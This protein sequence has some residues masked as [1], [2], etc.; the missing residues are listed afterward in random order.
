MIQQETA[1][2]TSFVQKSPRQDVFA[3]NMEN[4]KDL[5][6]RG[7]FQSVVDAINNMDPKHL[8]QTSL[9]R[10]NLLKASAFFEMQRME[11]ANAVLREIG[12]SLALEPNS[13]ELG[14]C[15]AR[16]KY[17]GSDLEGADEIWQELLVT[18]SSSSIRV[19]S[20]IGIANVHYSRQEWDK[21][22]AL[23]P[24]LDVDE[25]DLSKDEELSIR[26]LKANYL[27][28]SE[29]SLGEATELFTE[30]IAD[31]TSI[32]WNY[33]VL[34][35]I[36]GLA[37][38]SQKK[39]NLTSLKVYVTTLKSM[40]KHSDNRLLMSLIRNRFSEQNISLPIEV[41]VDYELKRVKI[42]EKWFDFHKTPMLFHFF[43]TLFGTNTFINKEAIAKSLWPHEIYKPRTHDPRI[44]N[45][46]K[47]VREI[48]DSY[49]SQPLVILSGRFGYKLAAR[50][51]K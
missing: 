34:R 50:Q 22:E 49:E 8:D 43:T 47:R 48:F 13:D 41:D 16:L 12:E 20:L 1:T 42:H 21:L 5:Y 45:I 30:I 32:N 7:H 27:W 33:F 3:P 23:L 18:S 14:H 2:Q 15:L 29:Q 26:M 11:E 46:A 6:F 9:F 19:R 38:I 25:K 39:Q 17:L 44:F 36:F 24:S 10:M 28:A 37:C 4:F 51:E 40:L 31:A 35:G